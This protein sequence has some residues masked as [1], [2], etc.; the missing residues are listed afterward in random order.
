[1]APAKQNGAVLKKV[2]KTKEP[3]KRDG[4]QIEHIN[5]VTVDAA[6]L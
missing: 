1:M 4:Y 2:P 6:R 3:E 5:H